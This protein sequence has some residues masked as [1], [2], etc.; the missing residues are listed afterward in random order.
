MRHH[1]FGALHH[2]GKRIDRYIHGHLKV[3]AAGIDVPAAQFV[4]IRK[5]DGMND[6]IKGVPMGRQISK[7]AVNRDLIGDITFQHQIAA[8]LRGQRLD[9][10]FQGV[11]LKCK[12][13]LGAGCT[14]G[15]GDTPSD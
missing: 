9:P 2:C 8:Q 10:L 1:F 6:E 13:Q 11:S 15:F 4:F 3:F 12:C 14:A 5:P 7:Q